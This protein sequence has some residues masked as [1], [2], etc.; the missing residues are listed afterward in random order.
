MPP[1][2]AEGATS[3]RPRGLLRRF[4]ALA[5]GT[6]IVMIAVFVSLVLAIGDLEDAATEVRRV[7]QAIASA[8]KSEK[9]VLDLET[10]MRGFLVTGR[11]QFLE[12]WERAQV[13]LPR[14]L[15]RLAALVENPSQKRRATDIAV[16]ARAYLN[17]FSRRVVAT[18]RRNIE[19]ARRTVA[20]GEGKRRVDA[21]RADFDNF[22]ANQQRLS[23]ERADDAGARADRGTLVALVALAGLLLL[24][25]LAG[26]YIIRVVV[27]PV[28]ALSRVAD[29][30]AAGDLA[31]RAPRAGAGEVTELGAAFNRMAGS[32]EASRE[33]AVRAAAALRSRELLARRALD[34]NDALVKQLTVAQYALESGETDRGRR[35]VAD[36]VKRARELIGD[37]MA[38]GELTPDDLR[39]APPGSG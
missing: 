27:R 12:P 35:A 21:V 8:N 14:E 17:E 39:Q 3:R 30:M 19:A 9:L 5:F 28:V 23:D 36:T 11:Q 10:G 6:V 33:E 37:L 25:A 4:L 34:L 18:G 26:W 1:V 7:E 2:A 29:R 31:A 16:A 32:L 22:L 15:D 13:G 24:L 20:G 38:D